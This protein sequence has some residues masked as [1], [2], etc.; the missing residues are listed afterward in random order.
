MKL[1]GAG[2]SADL[3]THCRRELIHGVWRLLLDDEFLEAYRHGMVI[4]C[5]DGILRCVYPRVFTYSAD[6]P[7]KVLLTTIRNLGSCP[8]PRCKIPKENI[9]E[10]GMKR[11]DARRVKQERVNDSRFAHNVGLARKN[12]Y[13]KGVSIKSKFVEHFLAAESYVPTWN[14]FADRLSE[15]GQ[16]IFSFFVVDLMH[17]FELGVWKAVFIH[18]I[19]MLISVGDNKIQ[20]FNMRWR[21]VPSFCDMTIRP[22]HSNVSSL[23]KMA[24]RDYEDILQCTL[25]VCE[26]LFPNNV[27]DQIVQ[28]LLFVLADWHAS[29]KLRMHTDATLAYLNQ[30]TT[31]LGTKL[32]AFAKNTCPDYD[33]REL[34]GEVTARRRRQAQKNQST[35]MNGVAA[36]EPKK[37]SGELEHRRVK[38]FYARTNK[39]NTTIQIAR[40]DRRDRA[41]WHLRHH[42]ASLHCYPLCQKHAIH[43]RKR[44]DIDTTPNLNAES[45]QH[46]FISLALNEP[47][48]LYSWLNADDGT[49]YPE[50]DLA[51][52]IINNDRLYAHRTMH[53][54]YTTYDIRRSYDSLAVKRNANIMMLTR[55][56][57]TSSG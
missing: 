2:P 8:C 32:R 38:R 53:V 16:N 49:A 22:F 54:H 55:D 1:T 30:A 17:E 39:R 37:K 19:R 23:K 20:E 15:F 14:A 57:N 31:T 48:M 40:L 28:D 13:V 52:V 44:P 33:T 51:D 36:K 27:H 56:H 35:S 29:A 41:L 25:P 7:E 47:L 34:P 45:D 21:E 9:P 24:A 4:R 3:L 43:R 42:S 6:Y 18:I 26:G 10:L 46:H 50:S 11:D 5:A 12:I